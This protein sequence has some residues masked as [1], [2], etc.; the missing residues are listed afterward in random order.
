MDTRRSEGRTTGDGRGY[1]Y[2]DR[3]E[4]REYDEFGSP[5]ATQP[6]QTAQRRPAS[7]QRAAYERRQPQRRGSQPSTKPF[8]VGAGLFI[9]CVVALVMAMMPRDARAKD[10]DA[11]ADTQQQTDTQGQ[12]AQDENTPDTPEDGSGADT[13]AQGHDLSLLP[14]AMRTLY[15]KV[16]AAREWVLAWYDFPKPVTSDQIDLSTLDTSRVPELYQ[17]DLRWGYAR[18]AGNFFGL[19]GCGPMALSM[20]TIY[21]TKDTALNPQR[22][23]EYAEENKYT[24]S[25][26]GTAWTLF[27]QGA[28]GLGLRST[29]LPLDQSRVDAALASGEMGPVA[30]QDSKC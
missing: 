23:G 1:S 20:V 9:A 8:I 17:W 10:T 28:A 15:D 29:E 12:D 26:N 30:I 27:S 6:R 21:F 4:Y 5:V 2:G 14:E 7:Q 11:D 16:P 13:D 25:G 24:D 19:S 18:Y 3:Q 22:V